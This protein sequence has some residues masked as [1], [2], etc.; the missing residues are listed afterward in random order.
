MRAQTKPI[1]HAP[2]IARFIVDL[3]NL[4]FHQRK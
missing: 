2:E 1:I 4:M 3:I